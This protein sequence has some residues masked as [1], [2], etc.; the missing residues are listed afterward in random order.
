MARKLGYEGGEA[1][2]DVL[3]F[4]QEAD[5]VRVSE[6]QN[7]IIKK[8]DNVYLAFGP[9]IEPYVTKDTFIDKAPIEMM[10][11]SW[12]NDIDIL[13][14]CTSHEG[15]NNLTTLKADPTI[16]EN[17]T[18]ES[19]L[20]SELNL[21]EDDPKRLELAAKLLKMYYPSSDPKKDETAYCKV[22]SVISFNLKAFIVLIY[23]IQMNGDKLLV[24]NLQRLIESRQ[25]AEV[26][27]KTYFYRFAFDSPV[28]NL[29]RLKRNRPDVRG[30]LHADE[31]S[32]Y[33]KHNY[34]PMV[35]RPSKEFT[36][37]QRFVLPIIA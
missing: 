7:S 22:G 29:F 37:I 20:P 24:H 11:T 33:F 35:E 5:P 13:I 10:K 34:G 19:V 25:N 8:E 27:G 21:S 14:G 3:R 1:D 12:G 26:K 16:L 9:H 2:K 32:Y 31:L 36:T 4:L 23:F 28:H 15:F 6:L 30:V 18:L 17:L